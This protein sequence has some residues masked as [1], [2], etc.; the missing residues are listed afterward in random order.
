MAGGSKEAAAGRGADT[1]TELLET[2]GYQSCPSN[3][4]LV[5]V[6][7][8]YEDLSHR[9]AGQKEPFSLRDPTFLLWCLIFL[10]PPPGLSASQSLLY[11]SCAERAGHVCLTSACSALR[12]EGNCGL[13]SFCRLLQRSG[14]RWSW[15]VPAQVDFLKCC[16]WSK[17]SP[18]AGGLK[19]KI[20]LAC[21]PIEKEARMIKPSSSVP[22]CL[23]CPSNFQ[24]C[25]PVSA[26]PGKPCCSQIPTNPKKIG[27]QTEQSN[28][29]RATWR[30][31]GVC[32]CP[33][34]LAA[35]G[36]HLGTGTS[37]LCESLWKLLPRVMGE[38]LFSPR[39]CGC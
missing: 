29:A 27:I 10:N 19:V 25:C 32:I 22:A 3:V 2:E 14:Q 26:R 21:F 33:Q 34:W 5:G 39:D 15:G 31:R 24:T 7:S 38:I 23:S 1:E 6:L 12:G 9:L 35:T 36:L 18:E 37:G 16:S 11:S 17:E 28:P 30:E 13:A 20:I 8:L 4:L